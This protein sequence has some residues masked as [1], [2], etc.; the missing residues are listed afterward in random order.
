MTAEP[1]SSD[2][3]R[4]MIALRVSDDLSVDETAEVDQFVRY[5]EKGR[6]D[7]EA[8]TKIVELLHETGS[9]PLPVDR[10]PSLWQRIEPRL[11]PAGRRRPSPFGFIPTWQLGA[12]CAALILVAIVVE[13]GHRG[14]VGA[15][16]TFR[17]QP[18]VTTVDVRPL[19][20]V[21]VQPV[22]VDL[23]QRLRLRSLSGAI[24]SDVII[25]SPADQAGIRA[26]DVIV[27]VNGIAIRTPEELSAAI[28]QFRVGDS[29]R[30]EFV[31]DGTS[32]LQAIE[33]G[34]HQSSL[35]A[36]APDADVSA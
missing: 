31:R 8:F 34:T 32:I 7:L 33:L 5:D 25:G 15:P 17:V 11:G 35:L 6:D 23:A 28:G 1:K 30:I 20:G 16:P 21:V 27:R 12:A 10:H 9:G 18:A 3:I 19:L 13:S 2:E 36:P 4:K 14:P 24:V 22:T 29:V 26:A